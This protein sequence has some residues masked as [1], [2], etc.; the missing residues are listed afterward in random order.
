MRS[1]RET[2]VSGAGP[3]ARALAAL[4]MAA[5][6]PPEAGSG[7]NGDPS[8]NGDPNGEVG[9]GAFED[10][11]PLS[12]ARQ[13]TAVAAL[14]GE[15]YLIG[16][17][18]GSGTVVDTV[19]AYDPET[20]GWREVAPLPVAMHH[21][22][23]AAAGG[24]LYV[25]GYLT[26]FT[27]TA[28]DRAF[29]YDPEDDAWAEIAPLPTARGAGATAVVGEYVYVIGGFRSGSA[30][31]DFARYHPATDG[32]EVLPDL[33]EPLDHLVAGAIDG[34][35]YTAGGRAA[36]IGAHTAATYAFDPEVGAWA[37]RA[38]MPTS[39]AGAA[40][41]VAR[42]RLYVFGGEGNAGGPQGMFDEVE[43][44]DPARD[45]WQV[46]TRMAPPRHGTGAATVEGRI[47]V[48]GG[49]DVQAFGAVSKHQVFVP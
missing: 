36:S 14:G 45:T 21:A 25:L 20:D 10:R 6:G 23:A 1:I 13:E 29:V 35:I 16:G 44:Y 31:T 33:D 19:E 41:A 32:W 4:L 24:R 47:Y 3:C 37:A 39:R 46:H 22:Q 5:C 12:F 38:D 8:G 2:S 11:M 34:V 27:F 9:D 48:P 43:S 26:A 15:V 7:G 18:D 17:F 49:A 40:G 42:G 28:H 30:V